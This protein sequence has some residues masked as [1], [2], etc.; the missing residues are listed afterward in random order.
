MGHNLRLKINV[1]GNETFDH[2]PGGGSERCI[3]RVVGPVVK[4]GDNEITF[5]V[6][7][8][9]AIMSDV[10]IWFQRQAKYISTVHGGLFD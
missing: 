7:I 5:T 2:S 10:V 1:N 8:G 9:E 3:Q 4:G 6:V